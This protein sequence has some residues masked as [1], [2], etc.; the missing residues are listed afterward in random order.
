[1]KIQV[2]I[3]VVSKM[4]LYI[5]GIG[6]SKEEKLNWLSENMWLK[7]VTDGE[8]KPNFDFKHH[9][10]KGRRIVCAVDN[11]AFIAVAVAYSE[12]ELAVFTTPDG[13]SKAWFVGDIDTIKSVS[14]W[15]DYK[16]YLC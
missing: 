3:K 16:E 9:A 4:G 13:R 8:E 15:E 2:N 1:M 10:D 7:R 5:N 12:R 6:E 14:N 11:G